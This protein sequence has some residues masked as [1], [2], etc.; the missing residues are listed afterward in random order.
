LVVVVAFFTYAGGVPLFRR[1]PTFC[2]KL[3]S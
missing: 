1:V 3:R 2:H